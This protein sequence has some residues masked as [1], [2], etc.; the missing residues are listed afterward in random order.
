MPAST[1]EIINGREGR[2]R[3]GV[4]EKLQIVAE[5]YEPGVTV[6]AVAARHD[7]YAYM[8]W[9]VAV[10]PNPQRQSSARWSGFCPRPTK[11]PMT[12]SARRSSQQLVGPPGDILQHG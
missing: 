7:V 9:G 11:R 2:R 6:G 12:G 5:T 3:W 4:E 10:A 1:I 8:N